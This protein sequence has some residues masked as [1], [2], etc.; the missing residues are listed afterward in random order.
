MNHIVEFESDSGPILIEIDDNSAGGLTKI[1]RSDEPV[2]SSKR[3]EEAIDLL[4]RVAKIVVSKTSEIVQG[5]DEFSV[6]LGLAFKAETGVVI[7][8]ASTE[9]NLKVTMKWNKTSTKSNQ[10]QNTLS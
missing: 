6:E 10:A 4:K 8:K 2:K 9:G 3:F 7:A 5:P 1:N